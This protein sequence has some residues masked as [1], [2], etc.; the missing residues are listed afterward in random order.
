[1]NPTN[2]HFKRL[3]NG[4][5]GV[6]LGYVPHESDTHVPVQ[7]RDGRIVTIKLGHCIRTCPNYSTTWTIDRGGAT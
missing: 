1:M 3:P 2:A 7:R 4:K 5:W 6:W